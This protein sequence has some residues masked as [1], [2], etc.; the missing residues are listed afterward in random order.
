MCQEHRQLWIVE[1][2]N[3]LQSSYLQKNFTV[4]L[5]KA[6]WTKKAKICEDIMEEI[7]MLMSSNSN[8][9]QQLGKPEENISNIINTSEDDLLMTLDA[10]RQ[11]NSDLLHE[12]NGRKIQ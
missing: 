12:Y 4:E 8:F 9:R 3:F 6:N 2:T 11:E 10:L 7:A 5:Q 1:K